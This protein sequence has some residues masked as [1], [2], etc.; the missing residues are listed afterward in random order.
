M[1]HPA[2]KFLVSI[3]SCASQ[4]SCMRNFKTKPKGEGF[5][6]IFLYDNTN[7]VYSSKV[8]IPTAQD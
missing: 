2:T 6:Y 7:V 5:S 4:K 3:T 8:Q 1:L